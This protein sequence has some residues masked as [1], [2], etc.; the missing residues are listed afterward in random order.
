M[1]LHAGP[2]F[3]RTSCDIIVVAYTQDDWVRIETRQYR[4]LDELHSLSGNFRSTSSLLKDRALVARNWSRYLESGALSLPHAFDR[5]FHDCLSY[6]RNSGIQC[7][8]DRNVV[9]ETRD[10]ADLLVIFES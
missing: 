2:P 3:E 1:N 6:A 9:V 8:L 4:I 7:A 5:Q 10:D